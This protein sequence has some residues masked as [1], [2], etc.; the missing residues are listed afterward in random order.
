MAEQEDKF[1]A[2]ESLFASTAGVTFNQ[3]L[4][5]ALNSGQSVLQSD[6][7]VIY[8]VFLMERVNA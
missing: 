2:L 5:K 1:V 6:Q 7:G 4:T 8:E 3:A